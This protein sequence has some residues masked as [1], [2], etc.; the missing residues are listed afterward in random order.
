MVV[1]FLLDSSGNNPVI[2]TRIGN[3]STALENQTKVRKHDKG[4]HKRE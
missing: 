2:A 3:R 1:V 4:V